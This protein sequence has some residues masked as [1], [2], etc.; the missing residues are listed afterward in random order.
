MIHGRQPLSMVSP[1]DL[2]TILNQSEKNKLREAIPREFFMSYYS[3]ELV[4][5][6]HATGRGLHIEWRVPLHPLTDGKHATYRAVATLRPIENTTM[7]SGF[8]LKKTILLVS[9]QKT[10]YAEADDLD[11]IH[12][13]DGNSKLKLGQRTFATTFRPQ[14][15]CLSSLFTGRERNVL[16]Q[17]E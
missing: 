5:F 14:T 9:Q 6:V 12:H 2:A 7:G 11:I 3:F 16:E 1:D 13:C 8:K 15:G 10:N 4:N 17:C